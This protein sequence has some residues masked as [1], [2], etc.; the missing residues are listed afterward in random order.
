MGCQGLRDDDLR[1][2]AALRNIRGTINLSGCRG[3]SPEAVRRLQDNLPQ[4]SVEKQDDGWDIL[5]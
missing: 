3:V 2:F 4:C 1:G 5:Q